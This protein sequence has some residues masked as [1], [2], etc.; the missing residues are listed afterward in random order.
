[1]NISPITYIVRLF[2]PISKKEVNNK[3]VEHEDISPRTRSKSFDTYSLRG[4]YSSKKGFCLLGLL[5]HPTFGP[6]FENYAKIKHAEEGI[7]FLNDFFKLND[8]TD[9]HLCAKR[10]IEKYFLDNSE[11]TINLKGNNLS[12]LLNVYK[13]GNYTLFSLFEDVIAEVFDDIKNSDTLRNFIADN[14]DVKNCVDNIDIQIL[15][16]WLKIKTMGFAVKN[17]DPK[18]INSIKLC[19]SI[20]SCILMEN[21]KYKQTSANKIISTYLTLGA[22]FYVMVSKIY[23]ELLRKVH[24]NSVLYDLEYEILTNLSKDEKLMIYVRKVYTT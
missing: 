12:N 11:Y 10:L 9:V 5:E 4:I 16:N 1:M 19:I 20:K 2:S 14:E 23:L 15:H 24:N 3:L 13:S 22:N 18:N 21:I 17:C 6:M 7:L 8:N